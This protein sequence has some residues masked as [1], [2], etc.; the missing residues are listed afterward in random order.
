[1]YHHVELDEITDS[2]EGYCDCGA[3]C[4]LSAGEW[5]DTFGS[6]ECDD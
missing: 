1:M 3:W 5:V 2:G 6:S 4:H